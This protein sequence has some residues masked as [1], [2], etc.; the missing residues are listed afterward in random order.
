MYTKH[1]LEY[2][3]DSASAGTADEFKKNQFP[4]RS[5]AE[6]YL[7]FML[8]DNQEVFMNCL[9]AQKADFIYDAF[10][11]CYTLYEEDIS[12]T[13]EDFAVFDLDYRDNLKLLIIN[14][15]SEGL[16]TYNFCQLILVSDL[17]EDKLHCVAVELGEDGNWLLMPLDLEA[18]E[19]GAEIPAPT[20]T[21]QRLEAILQMTIKRTLPTYEY[22][23][24]TCP[25]CGMV[26]R[27]GLTTEEL[28]GYQ[29]V[30]NGDADL[31][32]AIPA[33]NP[34]E[35]EFLITGMCP[36]CQSRVFKKDLPKALDR[37]Q[38]G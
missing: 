37:W 24:K 27:L 38:L 17:Q 15:P 32:E 8:L 20:D 29:Q 2:Y 9:K 10:Y 30:Q 7:S 12:F 36:D 35:R 23:T 1:Y 13:R 5:F 21:D 22:I 34:F 25:L 18:A 28:E 16:Q 33:L 11:R 3:D 26:L 14:L 31:E 19:W 6:A 4:P